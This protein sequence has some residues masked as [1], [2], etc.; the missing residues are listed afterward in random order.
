MSAVT[1]CARASR[2]RPVPTSL[3][4]CTR[5]VWSES[6]VGC[7][8]SAVVEEAGRTNVASISTGVQHA[9]QL[10]TT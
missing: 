9:R 5:G 7:G 3:W 8:W 6:G 4:C 10:S 1:E 2:L